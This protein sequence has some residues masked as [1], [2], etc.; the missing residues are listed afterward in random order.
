[1][2]STRSASQ[3]NRSP[4]GF[5]RWLIA[6]ATELNFG[7]ARRRLLFKSACATNVVSQAPRDVYEF[8]IEKGIVNPYGIIAYG[9]CIHEESLWN[10][11]GQ[12]G[13]YQKIRLLISLRLKKRVAIKHAIVFTH[14]IYHNYYHFLHECLVK[15][16]L[17]EK[18]LS[19]TSV[20]I[21]VPRN[22]SRSH[23]QWL[24]VL[25][26][27]DKVV[28]LPMSHVA[29]CERIVTSSLPARSGDHHETILKL[30]RQR[31]FQRVGA[32]LDQQKGFEEARPKKIFV[33]RKKGIRRNLINLAEI[34]SLLANHGFAYVELDDMD[35]IDQVAL[36]ANASDIVAIHGAA[37]A[38]MIFCKETANVI[39]LIN[40]EY[41]YRSYAKIAGI[42]NV[43][44]NRLDC[45]PS[46]SSDDPDIRLVSDMT[47]PT[48][49]LEIAID[50]TYARPIKEQLDE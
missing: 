14:P 32:N 21:V 20:S 19:S 47:V 4:S 22:F 37:L 39:E 7:R 45:E 24:E 13:L 3:E 11:R 2:K 31:L 17:L 25:N 6:I 49:Q 23:L 33:G 42:L 10:I 12:F 41:Q 28:F 44:Y 36:F 1:M 46:V 50:A 9:A 40:S 35:V 43:N 16:F 29:E 38:N 48:D 27:M 30:Y 8:T 34:E 18:H 15:L 5:R 26:L